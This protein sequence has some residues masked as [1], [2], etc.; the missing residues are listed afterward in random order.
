MKQRLLSVLLLCTMLIGVVYAQN[1]QVR[2]KVTSAADGSPIGGV[3]VLVQGT[4]AGTQTD[5]SGNY[6]VQVGDN[7]TLTFR[8][9]GYA[10][11]T[12]SV[13]SQSVINVQLIGDDNALEEVIVTGAY[14]IRE[15]TRAS[16]SSAQT[17]TAEKVNVTRQ[18]N[19]NNSL[20]GQINGL[21]VRS[22]S[23]AALG[24]QTEI[25]LRGASGFSS[26]AGA[27][28]VVDGTILPNSDDINIDDVESVSVL[29]G[30]AA[31]AQFGSQ[32][33]NGAVV[34]TLKKAYRGDYLGVDV[35]V[36]ANFDNAYI[37]PNYQNSYAGGSSQ[38]M[39]QY[40]W[41]SNH[42]AEWK[43]LDGKYYHDYSDDAS[44]G[45][46]MVGQEYI[47][48]YAWYGGHDRSFKTASLTPQPDNARDYFETGVVLNNGISI[49]KG[50]DN[51]ATRFS[52]N[53]Q[54]VNGLIPT[55]GLDRH[56]LNF[57]GE[58]DLNEKFKVG[59][60]INY[61]YQ[62]LKGEI[63][64]A[65]SNQSTG[66]FSQWFHRDLDINILE[67][68]RGL[69]TPDGIYASW[70]K[71]NPTAY[72]PAN[73]RGFYAANYWYNPYTYY[74]L[75]NRFNQRDRV[76][77]NVFA[78]YQ[79]Y[80]D[81][82]IQATYRKQQNTTFWETKYSSDLNKSGLQ[83]TG[84]NALAKG[85]YG[86]GNTYSNRRNIE[87]LLN[88]R[89]EIN[90]FSVDANLIADFYRS[91]NNE[92]SG[93]TVDGLTVDNL[94]TLAN[95]VSQA[96]QYNWREQEAYNALM[97]RGTFGYKNYL[98]ANLTLRNDW[99]STLPQDNNS[100]LSKSFGASFVFSDLIKES[101][102]WLSYGKLRFAW[103]EIPKAL[104][105]N[106]TTFGAYRYPGSEYGVGQFKWNGNSLT[107]TPDV[108]VDPDIKGSVVTQKDLGLELRFLK[109]RI[110]AEFTYF[111]GT[112][113]GFPQSITINGATGYS[114]LLTN[115]G[116]I[117]KQGV[118]FRVFGEPVQTQ[119]FNW[120]IGATYSNLVKNDVKEISAKYDINRLNVA[121][122][123]GSTMPY[124]VHKEGMRWG[125]I[126][127]NG[128]KRNDQGV[129]ILNAEGLYENDPAV[130]FGSVLP[131]HTGGV[132]NTFRYKDFSLSANIDW[133]IGGKF[134]SL[135]NMFGS[136][137]GLTARTAT[138]N[139]KGNPI[140]DDVNDGGGVRVDGV[141]KDNNPVTHYVGAQDYYHWLNDNKT[142]DDFIY[143]LT[144]VKLRA[145]SIGYNIP[146]NKL[147]WNKVLRTASI[148]IVANN[149]LLLY[150]KTKDFDPSEVSAL[151][152]ETGQLPGTRGF[153]FNLRFGF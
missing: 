132:Q 152:G 79:I 23:A 64:D 89:K 13:G 54:N 70:N 74:D 130:F 148:S 49:S 19:L 118:E 34:I 1:R 121:G 45:P 11:Q 69:T 85:Y 93:N 61:I 94:Y 122:V 8:Y 103:G 106:S 40:V 146:V 15:N 102:P 52:Y 32:G 107:S 126:Y 151:Q 101:T 41:Q 44:W 97:F 37:M 48:W 113:I 26:G 67:E 12:I 138:V 119:D 43:A 21:Q 111:D 149:P 91:K 87:F 142:Y 124:L 73:E 82:S 6:S 35:N 75:I 78:R 80:S 112:E 31:S 58:L 20:A 36:G 120:R 22:Q 9:I 72:N 128:I 4:N 139:D 90:D 30:P 84:N 53:N 140:R 110:G 27:I 109:D 29:Q 57:S 129:P 83:T 5:G 100:V 99:F 114:T 42:P 10:S 2:G 127:G 63:D 125:Q 50:G 39:T 108:I 62:N 24:R 16:V 143:D 95:S 116:E 115:V 134:V 150:A 59:A 28:Y 98:F 25:R 96:N 51:Y 3:S 92:N 68:L 47:P 66:S 135:S 33:A 7:A 38:A 145:V 46:R 77:G 136:Y 81:L 65:Y 17:L 123:W 55:S 18:P 133:S 117:V 56:L 88:Y 141:D 71:A 60:N 153:G 144:F 105:V 14:G 147:G 104:G 137:S 131:K 86:T 76:Y